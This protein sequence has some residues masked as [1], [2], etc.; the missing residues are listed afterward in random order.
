MMM[1][2]RIAIVLL[3]FLFTGSCFAQDADF[4]IWAGVNISHRL[5]KK[6]D[7]DLSGCVRTFNNTSQ[8]EQSFLEG[9]LQYTFGKYLSVSGSYRLTSSLEDDSKYYFRHKIFLDLKTGLPLGN[10]SISGRA[11]IQRTTKTYIENDADLESD[12]TFRFKLKAAYNIPSFPLKPYIYCEPF[13]PVNSGSG[14][15]IGKNRLSAGV[16]LQITAGSSLETEYIF[17]RDYQPKLADEHIIS[18]NY[19]LKF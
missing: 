9:G 3:I 12:Y 17:Q 15:E 7:I 8:I 1:I 10:F 14:F 2:R 4:G 6:I 11:R 18:I 16:L 19:K 5:S 13:I